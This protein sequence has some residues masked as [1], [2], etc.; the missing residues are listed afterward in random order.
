MACAVCLSDSFTQTVYAI[1]CCVNFELTNFSSSPF[2]W[3]PDYIS[4]VQL[5]NR[6]SSFPVYDG[7]QPVTDSFRRIYLPPRSNNNIDKL[8]CKKTVIPPTCVVRMVRAL[9]VTALIGLLALTFDILTSKYR[10]TGYTCDGLPS[11]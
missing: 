10:L 1:L 5:S 3:F 2:P 7:S 8:I 4:D 11:C 6:A 9:S